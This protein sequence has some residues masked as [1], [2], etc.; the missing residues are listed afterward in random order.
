M[1]A[2]SPPL[3]T[4]GV[5][6][7]KGAMAREK[8]LHAALDVFGRLGF[9]GATTR[10][11]AQQAGMNLG[12][13]PYYFGSKEDLY[14]QAASYLAQAIEN[15]QSPLL[16]ELHNSTVNEL[17]RTALCDRVISFLTAQAKIF[18]SPEVPVSWMHFFMRAQGDDGLAFDHLRQRVI[19]PTWNTLLPLIGRIIGCPQ[20][21]PRTLTL[22]FLA[23]HQTLHIRLQEPTLLTQLSWQ[24]F[25]P[26]R[27]NMLLETI[28][29]AIKS[30]LLN[31]QGAPASHP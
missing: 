12:A 21:D 6:A 14:A 20:E 10:M 5:E 9:D 15:R 29:Q 8:M 24:Q 22:T 7:T 1:N 23:I 19:Q 13:I 28:G 16:A 31:F 26:D 30:Q 11:L 18:L 25:T 17:D 3:L 4:E 2:S 27:M